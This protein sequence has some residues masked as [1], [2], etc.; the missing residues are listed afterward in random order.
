MTQTIVHRLRSC[1]SRLSVQ[2]QAFVALTTVHLLFFAPVVDGQVAYNRDIA[3]WIIPARS[4]YVESLLRGEAPFWDRQMGIGLNTLADPLYGIF[5]PPNLFHVLIPIPHAVTWWLTLHCLW[6]SLGI[7]ALVRRFN[8][9]FLG[10]VVAGIAWSLN[11]FVLSMWT[12]GLLLPAAAWVPWQACALV[13]LIHSAEDPGLSKRVAISSLPLAMSLLL[14][15]PFVALMGLCFA[16]ILACA[17]WAFSTQTPTKSGRKHRIV[18]AL[19]STVFL[20]SAMGAIAIVPA[21]MAAESSERAHPLAIEVAEGWSLHPTRLLEMGVAGGFG[22]AWVRHPSSEAVNGIL[23]GNP[24]SL[25]IYGGG[26]VLLL[27]MFAFRRRNND[28]PGPE[29][30]FVPAALM[31]LF[32]LATFVA[33]GRHT[34]LHGFVRQLIPPLAFMRAPEKYL[35]PAVAALAPL[36]GFGADRI[37]TSL[38]HRWILPVVVGG[39]IAL[40][41]VS[42]SSFFPTEIADELQAGAWHA[43]AAIGA[44]AAIILV[45]SRAPHL[46]P[47][48]RL[49]LIALVAV[50][51]SIANGLVLNFRNAEL[52]YAKPPVAFT[53]DD[54]ARRRGTAI[55]RLYRTTAVD[56]SP[57]PAGF[58]PEVASFGTLRPNIGRRYGIG[59]IP[60][61]DAAIPVAL[62]RLTDTHRVDVLRILSTDYLMM[63]QG[64]PPEGLTPLSDPIPGIRLYRIEGA[65]P[66]IYRA[67]RG[68][69]SPENKAIESLQRPEILSGEVVLLER[70]RDLSLPNTAPRPTSGGC[71]LLSAETTRIEASCQGDEP[72][73]AVLVEQSAPGWSATVNGNDVPIYV[74]N[75]VGR[76]VPI[77]AGKSNIVM[78]FRPPGLVLGGIVSLLAV[79]IASTLLVWRRRSV[80]RV[81]MRL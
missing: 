8:L 67:S 81:P 45:S 73:I 20:G 15:E 39:L 32:V 49:T 7:V 56:A 9:S 29:N 75:F 6:G 55:P 80:P 37:F 40:V 52:L 12:T 18:L 14:G 10:C 77:P 47:L 27:A 3:R 58:A 50:D 19:L 57:L 26:S 68:Q 13:W 61:Y 53:I 65:L 69:W 36:A 35:I 17:N 21:K 74:A 51:L 78:R 41:G 79:A 62:T 30:G 54:D 44:L 48:M 72:G 2:A 70:K 33:M 66:R 60:G 11:G 22:K 23:E 31:A 16:I 43:C 1:W 59:V 5:Y 25:S 34:P 64:K 24:L 76:A 71:R 38:S 42:A 46:T 28:A 63:S 4:F